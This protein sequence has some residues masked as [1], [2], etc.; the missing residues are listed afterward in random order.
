MYGV[1]Y[2]TKKNTH[3][4]ELYLNIAGK[5]IEN[6]KTQKLLG[7]YI[8]NTLSWNYQIETVCSKLNSKLALLRRISYFL[9]DEMKQLFYNAY[10]MSQFDYCCTV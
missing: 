7:I 4:K 8:D 6:V 10:I 5:N 9:T 3:C 1:I 2:E